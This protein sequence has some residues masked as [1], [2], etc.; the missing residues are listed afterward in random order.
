MSSAFTIC[1]APYCETLI[2]TCLDCGRK[3]VV[4]SQELQDGHR[5]QPT[6]IVRPKA[7]HPAPEERPGAEVS[8]RPRTRVTGYAYP[9]FSPIPPLLT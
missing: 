5:C 2:A 6:T 1:R 7:S 8:L 3:M 9:S 4:P